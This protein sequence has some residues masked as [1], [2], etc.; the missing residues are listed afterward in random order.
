MVRPPTAPFPTSGTNDEVQT[1]IVTRV[2]QG[3][4]IAVLGTVGCDLFASCGIRS[5]QSS[6]KNAAKKQEARKAVANLWYYLNIPFNVVVF[7]VFGF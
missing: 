7:P 5:G 2:R 4:F 3:S 6:L 1:N